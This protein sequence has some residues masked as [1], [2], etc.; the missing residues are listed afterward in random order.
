VAILGATVSPYL[1][2]FYSSGAVE[3]KW[4]SRDLVPN[5]GVAGLG[6]AFGSSI[7]M[8]VLV[9]AALVLAPQ[10]I[11]VDSFDKAAHVLDPVF[12]HWGL[13]L[14]AASLV[15]G[16]IGAAL[17]IG[18]DVSYIAAQCFGWNWSE[19]QT[20]KDEARFAMVYTLAVLVAVVPSLVGIDPLQLTMFSMV[21]TVLAIPLVVGPL[22]VIMNDREY[23]KSHTNGVIS[24]VAVTTVLVI[25]V[26]LAVIA[27]PA[28]IMGGQ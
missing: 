25:A 18:L 4:T 22:L 26:A 28:Q 27:I 15:I 14:F 7:A 5:R 20:P 11:V 21:L 24:N 13:R 6:M 17:E 10:G 19:N 1:V 12:G 2:T 8:A 3:E 9:V 23:L 16:C